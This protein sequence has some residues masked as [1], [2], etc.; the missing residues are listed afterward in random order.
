MATKS[1]A[2][3]LDAS[4]FVVLAQIAAERRADGN[5][6]KYVARLVRRHVRRLQPRQEARDSG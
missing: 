5:I 2:F 3:R 4:D 1:I 6:G